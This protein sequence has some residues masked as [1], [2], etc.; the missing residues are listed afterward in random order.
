MKLKTFI[1]A[2]TLGLL[3]NLWGFS[4]SFAQVARPDFNRERSFD[5]QHY[6]VRASFDRT[7]R[8]VFGDTTIRLKP[9]RSS[10]GEIGLD[11]TDMTIESVVLDPAGTALKYKL[12]GG[13]LNISLDRSYGP[14][15]EIAVRIKYTATPKRGVYFVDERVEEG[16][17]VNPKQVWTQGEPDEHR[18][19]LPSFD[20]PS[21]KATTEQILTAEKGETVISNGELISRTENAN[22]TVTFHYRMNVPYSLYL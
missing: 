12:G 4:P 2:S 20:F 11:A 8:K 22:D 19:W 10:F 13:K 18:H 1:A 6:I 5:V 14:S 17:Q 15:D 21:D 7:N 3:F 9:M 16:T